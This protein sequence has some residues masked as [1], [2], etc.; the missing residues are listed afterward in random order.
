MSGRQ[1]RQSNWEE[2][3]Q[4]ERLQHQLQVQSEQIERVF[5]Q[6]QFSTHIAGGTVCPSLIS[7]NLNS[8]LNQG[9]EKLRN[10]TNEIKSVLSV[11]EVR[12]SREDGQLKLHIT[13]PE[14]PP[15]ALLDLLPLLSDL[16][17]V[18]ATLGLDESGRPI[19]LDFYNP[20]VTHVLVAGDSGAGKTSLLRT[21][22]TSLALKNRQSNLQLL[23]IDPETAGS[24][25]SYKILQPLAFLPH[26][27]A[28]ISYRLE[29]AVETLN[30]LQGEMDYR[31]EQQV[32]LPTIM[33]MVDKVDHLLEVGDDAVRDPLLALLQ[34]GAAVGI[35]CILSCTNPETAVF[36]NQMR[37]NLPVRLVG[38]VMDGGAAQAATG[39]SDTQAEYLLGQGDF[40]A[41]VGG[42][43]SHFQAAYIGDYDLHLCLDDLHR[44][45]PLPLL[46]RP[47]HLRTMLAQ[48]NRST[49]EPHSFQF[50]GWE[51]TLAEPEKTAKYATIRNDKKGTTTDFHEG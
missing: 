10:L 51:I 1:N 48:E 32:K 35:H 22:A 26:M 34:C 37:A 28:G 19:L 49:D 25:K 50:D 42:E 18:T 12:I 31:R 43:A 24:R 46:A 20:D 13:R 5:S 16:P 27:L 30:F 36:D 40:L 45:Q 33:L 44:R 11:P 38:Q 6:H 9:W 23:L 29:E 17:P 47:A 3:E 4:Q 7:F 39:L 21:I 15:V 41:I 2:P 8:T 14:G